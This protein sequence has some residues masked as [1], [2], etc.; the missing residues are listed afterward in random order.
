MFCTATIFFCK[1][2]WL[3]WLNPFCHLERVPVECEAIVRD[4]WLSD[5]GHKSVVHCRVKNEPA[6]R[7]Q[8]DFGSD[9]TMFCMAGLSLQRKCIWL[10]ENEWFGSPRLMEMGSCGHGSCGRKAVAINRVESWTMCKHPV[11]S[12]V[13]FRTG[14]SDSVMSWVGYPVL[15]LARQNT[16]A[17]VMGVIVQVRDDTRAGKRHNGGRH[18]S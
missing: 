15:S 8:T 5:P 11:E 6:Q 14:G 1:W 2:K 9:S 13:P 17:I 12:I 10:K 7:E 3:E 18:S 16:S 4:F